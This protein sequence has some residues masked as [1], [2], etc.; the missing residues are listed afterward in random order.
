MLRPS[1]V[2]SMRMPRSAC[3]VATAAATRPAISPEFGPPRSSKGKPFCVSHERTCSFSSVPSVVAAIATFCRAVTR[4][5]SWVDCRTRSS[6]RGKRRAD[7]VAS[8][9][10]DVA[11]H[12]DRVGDLALHHRQLRLEFAQEESLLRRGGKK[13]EH[14]I[15]M[16]I[17]HDEDEVGLRRT[18]S[19]MSGLLRICRMSMPE[20]PHHLHRMMDSAAGPPR[21]RCPPKSLRCRAGLGLRSANKPCA[22]GLRQILPVQTKRTVRIAK[23][24]EDRTLP[25][26]CDQLFLAG[27]I[28]GSVRRASAGRSRSQIRHGNGLSRERASKERVDDSVLRIIERCNPD[29]SRG[30]DAEQIARNHPSSRRTADLGQH[31]Y[32]SDQ[33]LLYRPN[34]VEAITDWP[35]AEDESAIRIGEEL[36][37]PCTTR[38]A[39]RLSSAST[40]ARSRA[41]GTCTTGAVAS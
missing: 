16:P 25:Y 11:A 5:S 13:Q 1:P 38:I 28:L 35:A 17:S 27:G 30:P 9:P 15:E 18:R 26:R 10:V 22:M 34:P 33:P 7:F 39:L 4:T 31:L 40:S 24:D 2:R 32:C 8:P 29:R 20:L 3:P 12:A 37:C 19:A 41:A 14:R 21:H 23:E 6:R 36:S